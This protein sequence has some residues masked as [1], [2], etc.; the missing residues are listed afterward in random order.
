[1]CIRDS[2]YF[3][4]TKSWFEWLCILIDL[5]PFQDCYDNIEDGW[6]EG[7]IIR[8]YVTRNKEECGNSCCENIDCAVWVWRV[9]DWACHLKKGDNLIHHADSGHWTAKKGTLQFPKKTMS[10][11]TINRLQSLSG[12]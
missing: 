9:F 6:Y 8:N 1:M 3:T 7:E 4:Y 2:F 10:F 5:F 11:S 12:F